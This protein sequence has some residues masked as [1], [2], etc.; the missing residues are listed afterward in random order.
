[1]KWV[2]S[3]ISL[4]P[5]LRP[6]PPGPGTVIRFG[7]NTISIEYRLGRCG[8]N[9]VVTWTTGRTNHSPALWSIYG[10]PTRSL[11]CYYTDTICIITIF[12]IKSSKV[13]FML[14]V[15]AVQVWFILK[16]SLVTDNSNYPYKFWVYLPMKRSHQKTRG[17]NMFL[18]FFRVDRGMRGWF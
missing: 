3:L 14:I 11:F 10:A 4:L 1:M 2:F 16:E 15:W 12:H 8:T 5:W 7:L 18:L 6:G 13:Y 17:S 9:S